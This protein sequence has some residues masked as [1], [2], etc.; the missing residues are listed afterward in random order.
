[1]FSLY[2]H[3]PFC[4][5]VCDYCDFRVLP[6]SEKLFQEY[7]D[8]VCREIELYE[9]RHPGLLKTA[10]TLYLGGGT[11]SMLP[12]DCLSQ[13][14]GSLQS[15]G[16]NIS[17]LREISMEF[18]P[19]STTPE[20]V[21][22]ALKL[23]VKRF[24]LGLQTFDQELLARIGRAHSVE[25]GEAALRLLTDCPEIRV[26]G[27]LMFSLPGQS[28]EGFLRDVDRLSEFPLT[29]I[30]FYGLTV[31]PRTILGQKVQKE[32]FKIDED[33]YEP[34]YNGGVELL[35]RK[36]FTRYEVSNF[37]K[38]GF[39]S[40]HNQNYWQRGEYAGFGPGAHS[41]VGNRRFFAPEIY[42]RWR[43]Y[44]RN[45]APEKLLA[46]DELSEDD[47]LMELFWLSL[48]QSSGLDLLELEKLGYKLPNCALEK[49][50]KHGYLQVTDSPETVNIR[51]QD[52]GWIFMD[53]IVTDLA[54]RCSKLE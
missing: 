47:V 52:R 30:S 20:T 53:D 36:G 34:M 21:E 12:S 31:N 32:I 49:W 43:D 18:N 6:A 28:V 8:L 33:L 7:S 50:L 42:P 22:N 46:V 19:E 44:V 54:N 26:S 17:G 37:A 25:A 11:P 24:S 15:V 48:R 13:V 51:L 38:P 10:E 35:D 41:Y 9:N 16:V 1:M 3:I 23:G 5:K 27:D 29:H 4:K 45:G 2:I 40:I 39:E 14:F